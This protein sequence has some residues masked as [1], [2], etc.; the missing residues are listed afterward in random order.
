MRSLT[1]F[2]HAKT[3]S[4]SP[5]G[6][7]F[8][9]VLTGRGRDDATKMGAEMRRLGLAFDLVLASPA[10]RS[11]E[12]VERAALLSPRFDERIYD[13]SAKQLLGIVQEADDGVDRLMMV[14][15]N[16]GFELL[17]SHLTGKEFEMS[18]GSLAEIELP[19]D[20]WR[21]AEGGSGR[22]ARLIDPNELA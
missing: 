21:D 10:R 19:I 13:A 2:R 12:T 7:D 5:T 22:L 16:P 1:L 18:A 9:R 15:H 20:R 17:A 14:G 3:E 6:H 8:D 11:A 4:D